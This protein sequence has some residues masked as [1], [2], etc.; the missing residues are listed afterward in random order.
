MRKHLPRKI[1]PISKPRKWAKERDKESQ[2]RPVARTQAWTRIWQKNGEN[3]RKI[4]NE[5]SW[6]VS[7]LC[8]LLEG[9]FCAQ[10][11]S[12]IVISDSF[13]FTSSKLRN[14]KCVQSSTNS[15]FRTQMQRMQRQECTAAGTCW[16]RCAT[17]TFKYWGIQNNMCRDS[18]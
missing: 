7:H 17:K 2:K 12:K 13:I 15:I 14:A 3:D 5:N 10:V 8:E 11:N 16:G 4:R 9:V 18:P 6:N 1:D